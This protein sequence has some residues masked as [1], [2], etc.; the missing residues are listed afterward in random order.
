MQ[1]WRGDGRCD[2]L[3]YAE[4]RRQLRPKDRP[5]LGPKDR[6]GRSRWRFEHA[7]IE[8]AA[9]V[10]R[11]G[12]E[13]RSEARSEAPPGP[14]MQQE[15]ALA[16]KQLQE[17]AT[18]LKTA[19]L[20]RDRANNARRKLKAR[21]NKGR[22]KVKKYKA[23][24]RQ[25]AAMKVKAAKAAEKRKFEQRLDEAV[26]RRVAA[27]V[28]DKDE[29][30]AELTRQ[31]AKARQRARDKEDGAK[32]SAKR[33]KRAQ[34]AERELKAQKRKRQGEL[35]PG[36]DSGSEAAS[37]LDEE[38]AP[39]KRA[40]R[41]AD[42]KFAAAPWEISP[43]I[44]AQLERRTAPSA[45]NA[46]I[47]DVLAA[48]APDKLVALPC[49]REIKKKRTEL[50]VAGEAMAAFRVAKC[51][52]VISFGFDESTKFGLGCLSTNMQIVLMDGSLVDV[53]L[54]GATLTAGGTAVKIAASIETKLF[55]HGRALL[56]GW[57]AV[58][59]EL[60]GQGSWA[61]ADGA[62]PQ[63]I[64]LHRLSENTLLMSDTCNGAR[65]TK[66]LLAAMAE[67]AGQKKIGAEAWTA[68]SEVRRSPPRDALACRS[69]P[70]ML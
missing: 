24:V 34:Q 39:P 46:N 36:L 27:K 3:G 58:H 1:R 45:I 38:D 59:E 49:E 35:V 20:Q 61:S 67:L 50:T 2:G 16:Q 8:V 68:L 62:D 10:R 21:V 6:K 65:A 51:R 23:T 55:V 5:V 25:A 44:W 70:A 9:L 64:G 48:F 30:I 12:P 22:E 18:S 4:L 29:R 56:T 52:R 13:L 47:T 63:S 7:I 19:R 31:R 54:R 32:L 11:R 41:G 69:P 40:R 60:H 43:I 42:G 26:E 17:A 33:L 53:V 15:L 37:E 14:S 28:L 57:R 66:R